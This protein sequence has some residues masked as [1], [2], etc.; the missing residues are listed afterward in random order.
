MGNASQPQE[1][2]P[3]P[4]QLL[5]F[6]KELESSC[7]IGFRFESFDFVWEI[8]HLLDIQDSSNHIPDRHL[9]AFAVNPDGREQL[10]D[11]SDDKLT[12]Y[13]QE[14]DDIDSLDFSLSDLQEAE[15]YSLF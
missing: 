5:D 12:I 8:Q 6:V 15:R 9:V 7:P 10:V 4:D 2:L 1:R 3:I 11:V 13:Q 14:G